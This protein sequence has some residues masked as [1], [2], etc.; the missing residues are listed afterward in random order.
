MSLDACA[1]LVERADPDR[2]QT[3][4]LAPM[5]ARADLMVLYA[6]NV[7]V[8]R[9]PWVSADLTTGPMIGEM[10]VQWWVDA[11]AECFAGGA[12]R[13]EVVTPLEEMI[14]RRNLPQDLLTRLVEAR[15]EECRVEPIA[16]VD[17]FLAD[18]GGGLMALAALLLKG[19]AAVAQAHGWGAGAA[20]LIR[21]LPAY[22]SR[23]RSGWEGDVTALAIKAQQMRAEARQGRPPR[24]SHPALLAGWE[25][26]AILEDAAE[27]GEAVR[28]TSFA[29][30]EFKK[31]GTLV[32]RQLSGRY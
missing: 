29:Q 30:S 5:P 2:F 1:K 32:Y 11:V 23:S 12:R 15:R 18:T 4:M 21:A 26:D 28:E 9:A 17:T 25:A 3:A 24:A 16:D 8:S 7:E 14:S 27:R 20:A 10:R 31:R 13:H 19:D 22:A 6:L